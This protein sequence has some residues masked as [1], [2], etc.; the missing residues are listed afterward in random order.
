MAERLARDVASPSFRA[1]E[2]DVSLTATVGVALSG[3]GP[4][5]GV[6]RKADM[7]MSRAKGRGGGRVEFYDEADAPDH[8]P[9]PG[10]LPGG[11]GSPAGAGPG[12]SP[13]GTGAAS[14]APGQ[15]QAAAR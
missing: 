2:A 8:P 12:A 15:P 4:A 11:A 7:A 14:G 1:G 13:A 3:M 9:A 6:L 10:R 5:G